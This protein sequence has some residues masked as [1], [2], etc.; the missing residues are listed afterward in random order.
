[1][2]SIFIT[3]NSNG[4]GLGLARYYLARGDLVYGLS[5]SDC[6]LHNPGL[7]QRTHDLGDFDGL[8]AVLDDL[9]PDSLDLAILNAGVLGEIQDLAD[10]PMARAREV[11]D[12]NLWANKAI[13]DYLV[14]RPVT[15]RQLILVSSG[16]SVNGNRGWGAYSLSKAALNMMARLYAH[17][18][19]STHVT[20]Y[21][22]GI[23]HT[24]VPRH[25][26]CDIQSLPPPAVQGALCRKWPALFKERNAAMAAE[27][28][29]LRASQEAVIRCVMPLGKGSPLPARQALRLT[30]SCLAERYRMGDEVH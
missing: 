11:M 21:A 17:E 20:A 13:I 1:M 22:P 30:T 15:S 27:A 23:I 2:G 26:S 14:H 28:R 12:I 8:P 3:G 29:S 16:A 9:L 4:L 18:M 7:H 25:P 10:T 24:S 5:R 6:P 19:P